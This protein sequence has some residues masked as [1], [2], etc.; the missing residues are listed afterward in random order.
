MNIIGKEKKKRK[1]EMKLKYNVWL[2][3]KTKETQ[4]VNLGFVNSCASR[5]L[6]FLLHLFFA[7][8]K[9]F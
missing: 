7:Y 9:H 2:P 6:N 4:R 5:K 3:G 1:R 8:P